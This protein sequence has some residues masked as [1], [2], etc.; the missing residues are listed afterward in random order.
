MCSR[1]VMSST[2]VSFAYL[3]N[4]FPAFAGKLFM[5]AARSGTESSPVIDR[6][7]TIVGS[8]SW[9]ENRTPIRPGESCVTMVSTVTDAYP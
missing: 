2:V 1:C 4:G 5:I 6:E 3:S 7:S 8:P 9:I